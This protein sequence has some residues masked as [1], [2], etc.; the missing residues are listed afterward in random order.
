MIYYI[1]STNMITEE[2]VEASCNT[3]DSYRKSLDGSLAILKFHEHDDSM[4]PA[5]Q[6]KTA[7]ETLEYLESNISEWE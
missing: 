5:N 6:G 3:I 2:M 7:K 4:M 1:V